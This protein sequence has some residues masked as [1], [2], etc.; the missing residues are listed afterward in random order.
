MGTGY[1]PIEGI[2]WPEQ[3]DRGVGVSF[4]NEAQLPVTN[5]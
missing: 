1:N 3:I 5:R 4:S 2:L